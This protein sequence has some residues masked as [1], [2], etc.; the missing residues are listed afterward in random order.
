MHEEALLR[1]LRRKLAEV[2]DQ[3][4]GH[5]ITRVAVEVGAL[6]HVTEPALRARWIETT[7]G[8]AAEGSRLEVRTLTDAQDPRAADLRLVEVDVAT[9]GAGGEPS[10][11][12]SPRRLHR[13]AG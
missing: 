4:P 13:S 2:A 11:R 10:P 9:G 1:D 8:T 7:G 5:P 3:N 6:C 12:S